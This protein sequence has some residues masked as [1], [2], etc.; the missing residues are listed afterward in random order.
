TSL[1]AGKLARAARVG[2][3]AAGL[4][5][6]VTACIGLFGVFAPAAWASLFTDDPDVRARAAEDLPIIGLAHPLL[7]V[8]LKPAS[9]FPGAA[10]SGAVGRLRSSRAVRRGGGLDADP[11][12]RPRPPG[13]GGGA[14]PGPH[15]IQRH[16]G[17]RLPPLA[18]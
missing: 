13:P 12:G 5:A 9:A 11:G 18:G 8:G 3:T 10:P 15:R 6:V 16:P 2:W 4:A 14:R 7:G 1:G 17:H